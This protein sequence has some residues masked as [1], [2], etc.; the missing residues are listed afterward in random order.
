VAVGKRGGPFDVELGLIP[1]L[2]L[3]KRGIPL[4]LMAPTWV[5][6]GP[7]EY[8]NG[9]IGIL[10]CRTCSASNFGVFTTGLH[11]KVPLNFIPAS[12]GN[13]YVIAGASTST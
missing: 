8:W 1:T 2:D 12:Y 9:G 13:W 7:E 4:I 3:T 5:T 6:V 10:Q 11:A